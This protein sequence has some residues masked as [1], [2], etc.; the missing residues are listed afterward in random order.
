MKRVYLKLAVFLCA[1][2]I[3][4][5]QEPG[6]PPPPPPHGFGGPGAF[7]P[8][9]RQHM[10]TVTGQPYSADVTTT[11]DQTLPDGN[12]IHRVTQGHVARD[13]QGRVYSLQSFSG[14]PCAE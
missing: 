6:P 2:V 10:K 7:G 12:T 13:G 9:M 5:A 14:G 1:A 4:G 11:I 3:V 8:G